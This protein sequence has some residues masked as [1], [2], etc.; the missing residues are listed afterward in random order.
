MASRPPRQRNCQTVRP[1]TLSKAP[2]PSAVV[3]ASTS[4]W[5]WKRTAI[6]DRLGLPAPALNGE[7]ILAA[8]LAPVGGEG[9]LALVDEAEAPDVAVVA[10]LDH[11]DPGGLVADQLDLGN[12]LAEA[13][14][15]V[16]RGRIAI[17]QGEGRMSGA[18]PQR[19]DE[20]GRRARPPPRP[21]R[22]N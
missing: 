13:A 19:V 12:A 17:A 5:R 2:W 22:R 16:D 15:V 3:A 4:G 1:R 8:K 6:R 7:Q 14:V 20:L 9:E 21:G 10:R 11:D 18:A